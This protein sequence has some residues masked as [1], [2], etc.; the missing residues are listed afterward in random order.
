MRSFG[1][2][3]GR[4]A[5]KRSR[6]NRCDLAARRRRRA[7]PRSPWLEGAVAAPLA[8][9][10][11]Q[12]RNAC[13]HA[14]LA[15]DHEEL[16]DHA[17]EP[18]RSDRLGRHSSWDVPPAPVATVSE[19]A[20]TASLRSLSPSEPLSEHPASGLAARAKPTRC[21]EPGGVEVMHTGMTGHVHPCPPCLLAARIARLYGR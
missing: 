4:W 18:S 8:L 10:S 1:L 14:A 7:C 15:N 3:W 16:V 9:A 13:R 6:R 17:D 20:G 19:C 11:H 5:T 21:K 12:R 2:T